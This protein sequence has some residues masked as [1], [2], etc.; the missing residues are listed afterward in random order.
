V[1][2]P[3]GL[4]LVAPLVAGLSVFW[5]QAPGETAKFA[6]E[7]GIT[8][9]GALLLAGARNPHN[10]LRA[11]VLA[12][13]LYLAV[14]LSFGHTTAVGNEGGSAFS[15]LT[16]GKNLLGDIAASGVLVGLG[17]LVTAVPRRRW[18]WALAALVVAGVAFYALVVVA[19][20]RGPDGPGVRPGRL[21][22]AAERDARAGRRPFGAVR[23][24]HPLPGAGLDFPALDRRA[25]PG[26]A[27]PSFSTR[28]PP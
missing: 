19:L 3:R 6:V 26:P 15:G 28:T 1:L 12:F 10:V 7:Y 23:L 25:T 18:L 2:W 5:S 24:P 16:N 22:G 20:R 13:G 21:P 8:V 11:L 27:A 4:L 17:A 14:A 9:L